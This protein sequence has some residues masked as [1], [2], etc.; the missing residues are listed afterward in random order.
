MSSSG[1]RCHLLSLPLELRL[2]IYD[3]A[4]QE[5]NCLTITTAAVPPT[6]TRRTLP[7]HIP[8]I[9]GI[10]VPIIRTS[11]DLSL[12]SL[13][14]LP[15]PTDED[16]NTPQKSSALP[17][18]VQSALLDTNHQI[19]AELSSHLGFLSARDGKENSS[20]LALYVTYPYGL[21]ALKSLYPHLL[22]QARRIYICGAYS[23]TWDDEVPTAGDSGYFSS[24]SFSS[25]PVLTLPA[26]RT[27]EG[28]HGLLTRSNIRRRARCRDPTPDPPALY[29]RATLTAAS[30]ALVSLI[31]TVLSPIPHPSL[32]FLELR[33]WLPGRGFCAGKLWGDSKSPV[34]EMLANICGGKIDM[35]IWHGRDGNGVRLAARPY[36][37]RREVSSVW[38]KLPHRVED[39]IVDEKWG[40]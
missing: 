1:S 22:S 34:V 29:S 33:V 3:Y 32:A 12:L 18:P 15:I 8:G 38:K 4:L 25:N 23:P 14:P 27:I 24:S 16:I 17:L 13:N 7:R 35:E 9:P 21:I 19:Y 31:R 36:P 26:P 40:S 30:A 28:R 10:H 37:K 11:Y 6:A 20:G 5:S 2:H 39:W